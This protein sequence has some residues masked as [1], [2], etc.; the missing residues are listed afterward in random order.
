MH[1]KWSFCGNLCW[2]RGMTCEFFFK[3]LKVWTGLKLRLGAWGTHD[4]ALGPWALDTSPELNIQLKGFWRRALGI[5]LESHDPFSPTLIRPQSQSWRGGT[6]GPGGWERASVSVCLCV[7]PRARA[8]V[9]VCV[10]VCGRRG[11]LASLP[12]ETSVYRS[13]TGLF[14]RE[15]MFIH[16]DIYY[17]LPLITVRFVCI[18]FPGSY[19]AKQG[20]RS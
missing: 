5:S 18:V 10:W 15:R 11:G 3:R 8:C 12:K 7:C 17:A 14:Y 16:L 4:S 13:H 2:L 20:T 9:C 1:T 19:W 6:A